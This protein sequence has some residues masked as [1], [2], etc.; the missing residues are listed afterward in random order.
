MITPSA[1]LRDTVYPPETSTVVFEA[2]Q[3]VA[4]GATTGVNVDGTVSIFN[5]LGSAHVILDVNG[6]FSGPEPVS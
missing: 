6:Y 4:S 2:G 5:K 1:L 3:T